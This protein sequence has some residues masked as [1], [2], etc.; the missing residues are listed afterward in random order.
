MSEFDNTGSLGIEDKQDHPQRVKDLA[1]TETKYYF[2][3]A[4]LDKMRRA[5]EELNR[6]KLPHGGYAG[7]AQDL[8]DKIDGIQF[9][10]AKTYDTLADAI[11]LDPKP[12]DGTGFKVSK[13]TDAANAGNYTFQSDEANGV[14]FESDFGLTE[15]DKSTTLDPSDTEKLPV[16]KAVGDYIR[17]RRYST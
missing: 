8:D 6:D 9:E 4:E 17:Y 15:D 5:T 13:V 10:S 7:T 11:A 1:G 14:R 12:A 3:A 16:G 2:S